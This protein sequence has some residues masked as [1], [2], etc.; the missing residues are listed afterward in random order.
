[1]R[2]DLLTQQRTKN[3][4]TAVVDLLRA[5]FKG[6]HDVLEA[7]MQDV[8]ATM[9][10]W[11][12]PGVANPLGATYGHVVAAEDAIL[13]G[14]AEGAAPL[15]AS[16]WAGK[17]GLSEM[18]PLGGSWSEWGR[19]V[20]VDLPTTRAYGQAVYADTDAYLASLTDADLGRT[21]DLS[22]MGLGQQGLGWLLSLMINNVTWHTGEISC[23]K[24]LQG[25]KG[26][27]F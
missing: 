26:Y 23:L 15:I 1:M 7:T 21:V 9:A 24:G 12:P 3:H 25:A 17:T 13:N 8:T 14:M 4:V 19:R 11:S 27:P 16:S 2:H 10:H 22:A 20:Q 5:Q 18:P 6:A